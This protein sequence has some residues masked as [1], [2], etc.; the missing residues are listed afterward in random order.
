M[1]RELY[2]RFLKARPGV[3]HFACHSHHYWPDVTR[4]A[5]LQSWDDS[6][7]LADDKWAYIF[8][9][10][11]PEAQALIAANLNLRDPARIVFAPNTHEF[12]MRLL[13]CLDLGKERT[14]LTTDSEFYSFERQ[15]NR[16]AEQKNLRLEKVPVEPFATFHER[17]AGRLRDLRP[18]LVFF[19][20][21]FFNSGLVADA[22]ELSRR[23]AE[24]GALTVVDAYHGFMAVP[25]D[26]STWDPRVFYLS[27][28]YKY[29]QGGEGCCFLVVPGDSRERPLYTGWFAELSHLENHD[30]GGVAY[31]QGALRF[32]GSTMDFTA[33][34]RLSAVLRLFRERGL[35][36]EVIHRHIQKQ[37]ALFLR[38]LDLLQSPVLNRKNLI[39]SEGSDHG[40]FL[41]FQLPSVEATERVSKTL[42]ERGVLTDSRKDR[43]RFG[44]G[45]YHEGPY[46]LAPLRDL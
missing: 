29:A 24:T 32:A 36:V 5:A 17:F 7:R 44:F 37:Q 34:Y 41:T 22:E 27:G 26:L 8:T 11:V 46:D 43:L 14:I 2:S 28:S 25:T 40:H 1:Y 4:E 33:L 6:A 15:V 35:S 38:E 42:R 13:S 19:S 10:K 20:Q 12:V 16:F 45:L 23:A 30:G 21:V 3:Q 39:M 18:D 9:E 31:P